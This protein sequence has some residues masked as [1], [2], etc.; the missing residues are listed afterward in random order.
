MLFRQGKRKFYALSHAVEQRIVAFKRPSAIFYLKEAATTEQSIHT[1]ATP[2]RA[3]ASQGRGHAARDDPPYKLPK[4]WF[5]PPS[6]NTRGVLQPLLTHACSVTHIVELLQTP[7]SKTCVTHKTLSL[8]EPGMGRLITM[9]R[10]R[11]LWKEQPRS[12]QRRAPE[13]LSCASHS[14]VLKLSRS[15]TIKTVVTHT[16]VDTP[17]AG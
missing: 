15:S 17:T 11:P 6:N 8:S 9:N 13:W 2:A 16:S 14:P 3:A 5:H 1:A 4:R 12:I 10:F 7:P